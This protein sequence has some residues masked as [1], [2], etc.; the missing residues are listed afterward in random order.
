MKTETDLEV[1][2][3]KAEFQRER[4]RR[5]LAE[6]NLQEVQINLDLSNRQLA[7]YREKN[8]A[9]KEELEIFSELDDLAK[10]EAEEI[11]G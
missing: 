1:E 5:E 2:K 7:M 10:V 11:G 4:S 8:I 3:Y 6:R 9:L